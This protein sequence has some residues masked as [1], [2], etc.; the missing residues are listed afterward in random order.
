MTTELTSHK[1]VGWVGIEPTWHWISPKAL[2]LMLLKRASEYAL[3]STTYPYF[4]TFTPLKLVVAL[5]LEPRETTELLL[6]P[7]AVGVGLEPTEHAERVCQP[8]CGN[9]TELK[10]MAPHAGF[11]PA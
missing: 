10:K 6:R 4:R 3:T 7:M 9:N 1:L 11:E 2:P 8:N 5:G